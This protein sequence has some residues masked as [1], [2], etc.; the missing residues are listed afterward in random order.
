MARPGRRSS[1]LVVVLGSSWLAGILWTALL[2]GWAAAW[3][4]LLLRPEAGT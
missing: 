3:A 4:A 1:C 2:G